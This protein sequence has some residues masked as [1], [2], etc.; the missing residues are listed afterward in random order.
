[1]GTP[2]IGLGTWELGRDDL[3]R[4]PIVRVETPAEAIEALSTRL[5]GVAAGGG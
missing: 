3:D 4:D 2:V 5:P 1:M